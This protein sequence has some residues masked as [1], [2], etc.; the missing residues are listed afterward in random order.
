MH[1]E[2][3]DEMVD[4]EDALFGNNNDTH[5]EERYEVSSNY[6]THIEESVLACCI[7]HSTQIKDVIERINVSDF[8]TKENKSLFSAIKIAIESNSEFDEMVLSDLF[9]KEADISPVNALN[10]ISRLSNH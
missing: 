5:V 4:G 3:E 10:E 7:L 6:S 8:Y 1:E 2:Q 9:S